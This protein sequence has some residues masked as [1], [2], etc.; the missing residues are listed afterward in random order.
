MTDLDRASLDRLLPATPGS[1]DW[2]DVMLRSAAF[3]SPRR[4]RRVVLA[5]VALVVAIGT[6]SAFGM[7]VLLD[8][9]FIGLPPKGAAPSQPESGELVL[10]Y[11]VPEPGGWGKSRFWLFAD[12]RLISLREAALSD[13]A[14]ELSTG[15]LEQRLTPE[16]V[17]LLRREAFSNGVPDKLGPDGQPLPWSTRIEV[18]EDDGVVRVR[19]ATDPYRLARPGSWLPASAWENPEMDAYVASRYAVCWGGRPPNPMEPSRILPLLP[20]AVEEVLRAH[21]VVRSPW[22]GWPIEGGWPVEDCAVVTSEQAHALASS[23]DDGGLE[24]GGEGSGRGLEAAYRLVYHFVDPSDPV[25]RGKPHVYFEPILPHGEWT[26][27]ACG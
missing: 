23:L 6:A 11:G 10:F 5:I 18:R 8:K 19:R 7:R 2:D 27:S 12:G 24:A 4:R 21:R 1:P 3:A 22:G 15:F 20:A 14:N 9:G 17:D 26:C 25:R 16:G 13:G